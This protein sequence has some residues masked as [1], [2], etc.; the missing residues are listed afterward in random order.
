MAGSLQIHTIVSMPFQENTYVVWRRESSDVLVIDP[1]LEP[2]LI[3]TFLDE[4]GL[5]VAAILNTH[6]HG[7]HIGGNADLKRAFPEAPLM[8]GVNEAHLLRDPEANASAFFGV[9][10]LSPEADRLVRE[11]E[12]ISEA[13]IALEVLDIP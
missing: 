10:I 2:G 3:L 12:V 13:G 1:G 6:G 5:R 11:G 7:D 9:P 4:Q 8:I